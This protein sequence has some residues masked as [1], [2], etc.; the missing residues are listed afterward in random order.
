V[1]LGRWG[2]NDRGVSFTFGA[3]IVQTFLNRHDLDL[4][5]EGF[6]HLSQQARAPVH[7]LAPKA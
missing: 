3:D 7:L 6:P 4:V 2:E 5:R 1:W